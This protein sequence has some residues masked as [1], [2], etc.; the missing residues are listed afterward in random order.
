MAA[1]R[2][3]EFGAFPSRTRN[4]AAAEADIGQFTVAEPVQLAQTL[5]VPA[6]LPEHTDQVGQKHGR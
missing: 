3:D 2:L 1:E 5:V 6:P 4:I